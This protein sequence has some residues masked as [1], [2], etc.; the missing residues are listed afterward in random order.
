[1]RLLE[2]CDPLF[3]YICRLKRLGHSGRPV[4]CDQVRVEI[5]KIFKSTKEQAS[6]F[7]EL[8]DQYQKVELPLVFFVDSM[9]KGKQIYL[10]PP[11]SE[12]ALERAELAGDEK[13][14]DIL[15]D[16]LSESGE[17]TAERLSVFYTC[18]GLG[19]TGIYTGDNEKIRLLM[20]KISFRIAGMMDVDERAYICPEAYDNIDSRNLVEPP[21]KK[22]TMII[23]TFVSLMIVW[24]LL[25]LFLF[26]GVGKQVSDAVDKINNL[27]EKPNSQ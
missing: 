21:T 11:W 16:T 20:Q 24:G 3:Q 9:L 5:K 7:P 13:F 26:R 14:F 27:V 15:D 22:L 12:L 19:F 4:E 1:M 17:K 23:V 6:K 18:L 25:Y 10:T 8:D 2:I